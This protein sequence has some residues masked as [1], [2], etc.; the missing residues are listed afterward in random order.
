MQSTQRFV[1]I[2][3]WDTPRIMHLMR[4]T[5]SERRTFI[6]N[7]ENSEVTKILE[8]FPHLQLAKYVSTVCHNLH[9]AK[10]IKQADLIGD[11]YF[12]RAV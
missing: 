7:L 9:I 2:G 8:V 5:Y 3:V 1:L 10:K 4:D 12:H 6:N 11:A